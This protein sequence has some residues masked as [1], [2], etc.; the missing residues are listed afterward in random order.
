M[1]RFVIAAPVAG[2]AGAEAVASILAGLPEW[3][4][5]PENDRRYAEA[6]RREP[7]WRALVADRAVG[8]MTLTRPTDAARDVHLL[9][10][11]REW[12]RCGVGKALIEA[13]L[14]AAG[15]EGAR[16]LTVRTLG[17]SDPSA[18]YARTRAAHRA[19]G[20]APLVELHGVWADGRPMML[21]CR[22]VR[23]T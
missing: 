12:H 10:V 18:A 22:T 6:A 1:S 20:F 5:V 7:T 3:F 14:D 21:L 2:D 9:A 8:V 11:R 16:F 23:E 15:R 19:M 17:P 13:A 4:G